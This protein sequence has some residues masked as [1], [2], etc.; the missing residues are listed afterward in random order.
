MIEVKKPFILACSP[1]AGG[2][3]DSAAEALARG[4]ASA[5]GVAE[6]VH[7]RDAA[8]GPCIDC[9]GCAKPDRTCPQGR[10]DA[11]AELFQRLYTAPFVCFASPIYFYHL[12]AQFKAFIDRGQYHYLARERGEPGLA[13]LPHRP[14]YV[15]L[16]AGQPK[17]K[18]LFEGALLTLRYFL[19]NYNIE[20]ADT[21][22]FRGVDAPGD[23]VADP[24]RVGEIE[25]LGKSAWERWNESR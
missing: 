23:L 17:G 12:P 25:A 15:V 16:V 1:R 20:I 14:A 4:I 9:G 11:S 24:D 18:K 13:N 8:V 5:G 21:L 6:L 10:T 2:N 3:S 19:V 22:T 7:L